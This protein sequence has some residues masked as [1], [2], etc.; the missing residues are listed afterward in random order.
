MKKILKYM[1]LLLVVVGL[2]GCTS[3]KIVGETDAYKFKQEYESLNGE[4]RE[5]DD[6]EYR[7]ITIDVDNP[8][9]YSS[10]DKINEMI[11][12]DETF[13]IYTGFSGCP[14]CRSVIPY[15]IESAKENNIDK[16]Y[17]INL[18]SK[19]DKSYD[20]RG[21][22]ALDEDNNVITEVEAASGYSEFLEK[23][24]DVLDSYELTDEDGN[25][26]ETGEDRLY[27][28]SFI[29]VIKGEVVK[30]TE[31]ISED[32]TDGYMELTDKIKEDMT[33]NFNEFFEYFNENK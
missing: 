31:G 5:K 13:I 28:P 30:L 11:D 14:W 2:T 10:F 27:A 4:H 33:S 22:K 18:R 25:T 20:L 19:D 16:I 9:V 7:S 17:Y 12:N 15:A 6:K 8:M 29:M 3:K 21:Y 1:M 24:D 26:Y 32:Q 23:C